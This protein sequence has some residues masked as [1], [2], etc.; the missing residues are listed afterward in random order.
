MGTEYE[1]ISGIENGSQV[2]VFGQGRLA[3]GVAVEVIQ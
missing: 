1:L 3:D 2:V